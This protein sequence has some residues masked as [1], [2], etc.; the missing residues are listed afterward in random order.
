MPARQVLRPDLFL[1]DRLAHHSYCAR[2]ELLRKA[3]TLGKNIRLSVISYFD[4]TPPTTTS[5]YQDVTILYEEAA[6]NSMTR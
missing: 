3:G 5:T 2:A 1:L 4:H 6:N